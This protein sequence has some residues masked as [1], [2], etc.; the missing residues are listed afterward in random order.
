[1]ND[2][3]NTTVLVESMFMVRD[4]YLLKNRNLS[5]GEDCND[6]VLME[7][8]KI[9]CMKSCQQECTFKYYSI[10]LEKLNKNDNDIYSNEYIALGIYHNHYP[11]ITVNHMREIEFTTFVCNFGGL[12]G[13]WLGLS[14]I[15]IIQTISF[16][17]YNYSK[18]KNTF[19]NHRTF[20]FNIGTNRERWH[21]INHKQAWIKERVRQKLPLSSKMVFKP[22]V[23]I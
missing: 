23:V 18:V 13:M 10:E 15:N 8:N 3:C 22:S 6:N 12:L 4:Q 7:K 20:V 17:L 9:N 11:D 19:I 14:F 2:Q 16:K 5:I 1:M 21:H